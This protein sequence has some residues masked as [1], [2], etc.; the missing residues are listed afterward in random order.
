M[1][2]AHKLSLALALVGSCALLG[3]TACETEAPIGTSG[4]AP[5]GELSPDHAGGPGDSATENKPLAAD[6]HV[7][8]VD[9][10][11]ELGGKQLDSM[12]YAIVGSGYSKGGTL[13][14]S[15]SSKVTGIIGG[16][17]FGTNYAMTLS[18]K[19]VGSAPLDC[20]GSTSFDLHDVGPV[21]VS[22]R[23]SCKEPEV[24]VVPS[25]PPPAP[26]APF[27]VFALACVLG[28]AGVAAQRRAARG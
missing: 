18:G 12:G 24:V 20:T 8:A 21:P 10:S 27:A 23:V 1:I 25:E 26:V 13:D 28:A 11:L 9:L 6:E 16:I 2:M 19:G 5:G 22:I 4:S 7:G 14:V 17:P 15:H 3:V